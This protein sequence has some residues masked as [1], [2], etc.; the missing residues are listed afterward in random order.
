MTLHYLGFLDSWRTRWYCTMGG[1]GGREG[2][3]WEWGAPPRA[4][5][6][7]RDG[8]VAG[9]MLNLALCSHL[10]DHWGE[11]S[12]CIPTLLLL[13]AGLDLRSL[14]R[15]FPRLI[16]WCRLKP[17]SSEVFKK[18]VCLIHNHFLLLQTWMFLESWKQNLTFPYAD[19][20]SLI[21]ISPQKVR[22]LHCVRA[23]H[24]SY[25]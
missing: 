2:S 4:V 16:D 20:N 22:K 1:P 23:K 5:M 24:M 9:C 8:W 13:N 7:W 11:I 10:C 21:R 15:L 14:S 25:I 3:I 19:S 18:I 17:K 12:L 6:M